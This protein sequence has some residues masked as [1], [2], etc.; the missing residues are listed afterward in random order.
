MLERVAA[1]SKV[2]MVSADVSLSKRE[3]CVA[4][5]QAQ[6]RDLEGTNTH[7]G[8]GNGA[9][10]RPGTPTAEGGI[11]PETPGDGE[12]VGSGT[13]GEVIPETPYKHTQSGQ[14]PALTHLEKFRESVSA[15]DLSGRGSLED[16]G[17][18]KHE[19]G[20][21]GGYGDSSGVV[22]DCE[23]EDYSDGEVF[24][25]TDI[26]AVKTQNKLMLSLKKSAESRV[27]FEERKMPETEA[28]TPN[29]YDACKSVEYSGSDMSEDEMSPIVKEK[30]MVNTPRKE[31]MLTVP[32]S[33]DFG[34][35]MRKSDN[36]NHYELH[37][38]LNDSRVLQVVLTPLKNKHIIKHTKSSMLRLKNS[39]LKDPT[40][41]RA[42]LQ[43][44]KADKAL[45]KG[46]ENLHAKRKCDDSADDFVE[47]DLNTSKRRK[48]V[49]AVKK[50]TVAKSKTVSAASSRTGQKYNL[51]SRR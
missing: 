49:Q 26:P 11:V 46:K 30:P 23:S 14:K 17:N 21:F 39:P 4:S 35:K 24:F 44:P 6:I 41:G 32:K 20:S 45:T 3:E 27:V 7:T 40:R 43:S 42:C 12:D 34:Q 25:K 50:K 36:T 37:K 16:R 19:K 51:R 31:N 47:S 38:P 22:A 9:P 10:G 29:I 48:V 5:L 15:L 28:V 13:P 1:D 8:E 33:F 2:A 18:G